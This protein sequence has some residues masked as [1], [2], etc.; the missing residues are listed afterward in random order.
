MSRPG[1]HFQATDDAD[2]STRCAAEPPTLPGPLCR[3]RPLRGA[4]APALA[5]H[6]DDEAVWH[7]LFEGF[8]RPY[9]V[10]DAAWW[11]TTGSRLPASGIVWG[12]EVDVDVPAAGAEV[13]GCIGLR[14]DAG[15][16]RCNA[17]VGYWIGQAH[18]RRGIAGEALR[19]VTEWAWEAQPELTRLYAPIFVWNAGSQAVARRCGYVFEGMLRHSAIKAGR[20][21]DRVQ[22]AAY[23][24]V[25]A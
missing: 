20:V 7:N 11:C 14:P 4:D 13:I 9:T 19:R 16:L 3:L 2:A 10:A 15:W 18:W 23:R 8:P 22:Y 12:I 21:I 6:A 17:E 1:S 5:R 25:P 24:A